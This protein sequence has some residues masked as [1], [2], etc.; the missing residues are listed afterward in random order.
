MKIAALTITLFVLVIS[1]SANVFAEEEEEVTLDNEVAPPGIHVPQAVALVSV[2]T[3]EDEDT[4]KIFGAEIQYNFVSDKPVIFGLHGM[5]QRQEYGTF[6]EW[7]YGVGL[8]LNHYFNFVSFKPYIAL[9][10]T[11]YFG[12]GETQEALDCLYC[13]DVEEDY[14]GGETYLTFGIKKNRWTV[15]IDSRI[16]D[17]RS[18][19]SKESDDPWGVGYSGSQGFHGIPDPEIILHIGYSW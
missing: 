17:N 12:L 8:S 14:S 10:Q 11:Y 9:K 4:S 18:D 15:Q 2:A 6:S 5:A 13:S 3:S 19:W 7:R 16:S 1:S